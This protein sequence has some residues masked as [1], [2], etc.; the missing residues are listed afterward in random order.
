VC[1]GHAACRPPAPNPRR[2]LKAVPN[3]GKVRAEL[4]QEE[5]SKNHLPS[6]LISLPYN[7]LVLP[8]TR[9]YAFLDAEGY[10]KESTL[11]WSNE[12]GD[13]TSER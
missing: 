11:M 6:F 8:N 2:N 3:R 10:K 9:P 12:G 5:N 1:A 13:E 7:G 4:S